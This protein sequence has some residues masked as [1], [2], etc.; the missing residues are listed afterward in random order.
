MA[1]VCFGITVILCVQSS[2]PGPVTR[3]RTGPARKSCREAAGLQIGHSDKD[4]KQV[5][6]AKLTDFLY[7]VI[8]EDSGHI[9]LRHK[10]AVGWLAKTDAVPLQGAVE[11]FTTRIRTNAKDDYAF[12]GRGV[13]K[14]SLA[15]LE[16]GLKDLTEAVGLNPGSAV[17]RNNR[18][19]AFVD[20]KDYEGALADFSEAVRL[21][22]K[23]S[24]AF[25]NRPNVYLSQKD[26]DK[27][28]KDLG[29]HSDLLDPKDADA[30]SNRGTAYQKKED[31]EHALADYE[32][33]VQL[34]PNDAPTA[35]NPA[36][37][38]ATCPK[39]ELRNGKK[40]VEYA[41]KAAKL[42]DWKNAG[43]LDTLAAAYAEDGPFELAG[44][45]QKK[46]LEDADYVKEIGEEAKQR[47]KLYEQGK[48][49][50][51]K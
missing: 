13:A 18:G 7:T 41:L 5:Y 17:W 22:P 51:E 9:L 44:K 19:V 46:A 36:W 26:Y 20:K 8:Q 25:L 47:L 38:L 43:I 27:A 4:G 33:A 42:S 29:C 23:Y 16:G 15:D 28:I 40:A 32:M 10:G 24:L 49:Y 35:N 45:W 6:V 48:P 31:F 34:D 37:L 50:R 39:N 30:Y 3:K 2:L 21:E 12:A 14:Q 1:S 11:F